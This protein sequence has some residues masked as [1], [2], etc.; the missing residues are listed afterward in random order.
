M[1]LW[2]ECLEEKLDQKAKTRIVGCKS[3]MEP[4]FSINVSYKLYAMMDNLS[5]L[6]QSTKIPAIKGKMYQLNDQYIEKYEE[7]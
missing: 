3:Q 7:G 5:K 6:L 4:F 2:E 1:R